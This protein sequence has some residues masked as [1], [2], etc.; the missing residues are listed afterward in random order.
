M[1][2]RADEVLI[3]KI[4]SLSPERRAE[5]EDFVNFLVAEDKRRGVAERF[6][7]AR[8]RLARDPIPAMAPEEIQAETD[9]CRGEQRRAVGA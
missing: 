4:K 3:E 7:A 8:E 5:V 6:A 9:A 2:Q 1:N